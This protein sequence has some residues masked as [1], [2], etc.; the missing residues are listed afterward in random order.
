MSAAGGM[1]VRG[2]NRVRMVV[3]LTVIALVSGG[4][5]ALTYLVSSPAIQANQAE[6][7]RRSIYEVV[8]GV[9]KYQEKSRDGMTY[10]ECR[11]AA[12]KLAGYAL[13]A[14]GNGYQGT[15]RL[16]IGVSAD[17]ATITG[18]EVLEQVETPGLGGRIGEKAFQ[19]QFRGLPTQPPITYVKNKKPQ[20]PAEIQAITGATISTR[21]TVAIVNRKLE[22]A[23]RVLAGAGGVAAAGGQGKD[24]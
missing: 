21:S 12:G 20:G 10:F 15:I 11:D 16:M 9:S 5:L 24:R 13:P 1:K 22:E 3:V 4:V 14:E 23:R 7:L 19:D 2:A 8:S 6:S 18:L 17:L